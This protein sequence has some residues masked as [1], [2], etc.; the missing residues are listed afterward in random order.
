MQPVRW[1]QLFMLFLV[2]AN[3]ARIWRPGEGSQAPIKPAEHFYQAPAG[4]PKLFMDGPWRLQWPCLIP[5][6]LMQAA[7]S[8]AWITA[9]TSTASCLFARLLA[10]CWLA[11]SL[12]CITLFACVAL[13][14]AVYYSA[15]IL[16]HGMVS[17]LGFA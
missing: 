3:G 6:A 4:A 17:L 14:I 11:F 15:S 2:H 7:H 1:L 13:L 10:C 5:W 16:K 9:A 8:V 12:S